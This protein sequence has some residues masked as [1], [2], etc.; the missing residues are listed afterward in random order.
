M[1]WVRWSK[2]AA[3]VLEPALEGDGEILRSEVMRGVSK[4]AH[5]PETGMYCVIRWE[6]AATGPELVLCAAAG[7]GLHRCLPDLLAYGRANGMK[8]WRA[9]TRHRGIVRMLERHGATVD[10]F[11]VRAKDGQQ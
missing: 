2:T 1:K 7:R 4:L 5:W 11:V 8:S 10:H 3:D 6:R 9:H